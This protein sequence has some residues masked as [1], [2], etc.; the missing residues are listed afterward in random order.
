M[1]SKERLY[2]AVDSPLQ[3]FSPVLRYLADSTRY[4]LQSTSDAGLGERAAFSGRQVVLNGIE[5]VVKFIEK[6]GWAYGLPSIP[7]L[8]NNPKVKVLDA[9]FSQR[10]LVCGACIDEQ[11]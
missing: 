2:T 8:D 3:A 9:N 10:P 11:K 1:K 5:L 6:D 7:M 4:V